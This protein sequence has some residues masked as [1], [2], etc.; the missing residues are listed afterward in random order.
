M[1]KFFFATVLLFICSIAS[2]QHLT[3]SAFMK[4]VKCQGVTD[5]NEALDARGYNY[6][7]TYEKTTEGITEKRVFWCKNCTLDNQTG[8]VSW[9]TN[10]R[11]WITLICSSDS[12]S[13]YV[14]FFNSKNAFKTFQTTAKQNGFKFLSEDVQRD[15][16][17]SVYS[18]NK[19]NGQEYMRFT[20]STSKTYSVG[21]WFNQND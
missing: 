21:Y 14:Y 20:E 19:N 4:I 3:Y 6:G 1:K 15:A 9:D 5:L 7:G 2:A 10:D 11:S 18:R 12:S 16:I 8:V 13:W 17:C